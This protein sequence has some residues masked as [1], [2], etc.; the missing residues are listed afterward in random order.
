MRYNTQSNTFGVMK[1][2]NIITFKV[3][4]HFKEHIDKQAVKRGLTLSD[5][6]KRV[7]KKHS[8]YKEP[9]LI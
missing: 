8:K 3:A 2:D 9:E 7:L 1:Q 6:V 5:Y 4:S